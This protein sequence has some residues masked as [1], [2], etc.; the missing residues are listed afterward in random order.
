MCP[1]VSRPLL[2]NLERLLQR[3][4]ERVAEDLAAVAEGS[5][6]AQLVH[7][8]G[9]LAPLLKQRNRSAR[10][11]EALHIHLTVVSRVV[12]AQAFRFAGRHGLFAIHLKAHMPWAAGQ[13][14]LV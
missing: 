5:G 8:H 1:C 13:L 12:T 9:P 10:G 3:G 14:T 2:V 11:R 4:L 6:C 7:Q